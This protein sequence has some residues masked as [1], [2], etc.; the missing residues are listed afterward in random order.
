MERL[1]LCG[2]ASLNECA[3][4]RPR[5]VAHVDIDAAAEVEEGADRD[6]A[7]FEAQICARRR[8]LR[9]SRESKEQCPALAHRVERPILLAFERE[10]AHS[11]EWARR[12]RR[13]LRSDRTLDPESPL[14]AAHGDRLDRVASTAIWT[15]IFRAADVGTRQRVHRGDPVDVRNEHEPTSWLGTCRVPFDSIERIVVARVG[16]WPGLLAVRIV[17]YRRSVHATG[18]DYEKRSSRATEK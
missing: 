18:H 10:F 16:P 1:V 13:I 4:I 12:S 15:T 17:R 9:S 5:T 3:R 2:R 11:V 6:A 14:P 7:S 8:R